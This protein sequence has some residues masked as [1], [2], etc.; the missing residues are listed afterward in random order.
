MSAK[1]G[2][3]V[4]AAALAAACASASPPVP[5]SGEAAAITSLAGR[6]AGQYRSPSTGRYGSIAFELQ[7]GSDTARGEV[8][9]VPVGADQPL[10]PFERDGGVEGRADATLTPRFLDIRFV[11]VGAGDLRGCLEPY[12]DPITGHPLLTTFRGRIEGDSIAGT[13]QSVD[14][15]TGARSAG[16]WWVTRR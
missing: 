11:T 3:L 4:L 7:A 5:V 1:T 10:H 12:R 14:E 15:R 8:Q 16:S 13:F 6:W 2:V 9:M